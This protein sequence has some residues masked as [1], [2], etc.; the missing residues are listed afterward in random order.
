MRSLIPSLP[1]LPPSIVHIL[2][3]TRRTGAQTMAGALVSRQRT[4]WV[5]QGSESVPFVVT[6]NK[7]I[8]AGE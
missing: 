8:V 5:V 6:K 1:H 2:G 7:K 4:D 3:N